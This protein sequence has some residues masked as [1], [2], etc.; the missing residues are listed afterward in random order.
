[1][2]S[3]I[4]DQTHLNIHAQ[5]KSFILLLQL[6]F[7]GNKEHIELRQSAPERIYV[8]KVI[9]CISWRIIADLHRER[10]T[11]I[12]PKLYGFRT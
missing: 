4:S 9:A 3:I 8:Y 12:Q 10:T 2:D 1:M 7:V 6:D 11:N 5:D